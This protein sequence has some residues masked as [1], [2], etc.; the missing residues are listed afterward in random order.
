MT[1]K[2]GI[3]MMVYIGA[4][5]LLVAIGLGVSAMFF[6][7]STVT[8]EAETALL[9]MTDLGAKEVEIRVQS[10][11]EVLYEVANREGIQGM[12]WN[13]QQELLKKDVG[14]LGY[15]DMA[16]VSPDGQARYVLG[17][18][19]SELGDRVY[20]K[21]GFS[22]QANVSDVLIS[23][24]T[25]SAVLMYAAPI[26]KNN[27]VVGVLIA[28]RDGNDLNSI[29]DEMGFGQKGYAYVI[30]KTGTTV[31]H[32]NRDNVME[33]V[34]IIEMAKEDDGFK[35]VSKMV[36]KA[37]REENGLGRYAFNKQEMYSA[38]APIAGTD[39]ILVNV[40][41][42]EEV[43]SGLE[44][45][46][47]LLV[48]ITLIFLMI[49]LL[50]SA[51]VG[52]S[53]SKP[54]TYLSKE[55]T[56]VSEYD[57][58]DIYDKDSNKIIKKKD[59]IGLIA[60][61]IVA[62]KKNL[63]NLIYEITEDAINVAASSEELTATSQQSSLASDEIAR[64][65]EDI[66]S[67]ATDQAKETTQGAEEI[68]ILGE[69]ITSE[70]GL[71][72][73]LNTSAEDVNRL[74]EEGL[75]VLKDLEEKT[76]ENN[77]AAQAVQKIIIETNASADK[78]EAASDMIKNIADQTNLLALN[79]AIEA[80]RA[81]EAG[82]GFAVVADEI[83]KLAEQSNQFAGEISSIISNLSKMTSQGVQMM[84]DA[85]KIVKAQMTSLGNTHTKFEGISDAVDRVKSVVVDLN[86]STENMMHKKVQIIEIIEN[87]SAISEENAAG[88]E[89]ASAAV[90][91]QTASMAQIS[92]ASED[93]SKLA[94]E[95][96]K[97]ISR[98]KI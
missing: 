98:F 47:G 52:R 61:A 90:E 78:I 68:A 54:I 26:Y 85:S 94:E 39:W 96:Q 34:N 31:A 64:T 53:I 69:I 38:Y 77:A 10:R 59:E 87:L 71:V 81:G 62:M 30:N 5:V 15:L 51:L 72:K 93:L 55:I 37:L 49:G 76:D 14:R 66:A 23:R 42:E 6:A 57:L 95:M 86:A 74:K 65:I 1:K 32:P 83:R 91:E 16:I 2:I 21:E 50:I 17:D 82:K 9:Q 58:T 7:S 45:M 20:V 35:S 89:E 33:Q 92:D 43:L 75:V 13:T 3:K 80:A 27:E 44:A 40:A 67:G 8:D 18:S 29:T 36:E 19:I 41:L 73:T 25:N 97:S 4:L 28:R 11:L 84:E 24:V 12:N 22:G 60:H 46:R 70:I 88:T 48:I 79:A 56:R 63:K